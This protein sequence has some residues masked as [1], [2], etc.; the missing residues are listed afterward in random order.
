MSF[1]T[2]PF[3]GDGTLGFNSGISSAL[4]TAADAQARAAY[5]QG[6]LQFQNDQLAF[7]MAQQAYSNAISMGSAY[8]YAPGGNWFQWPRGG[9]PNLTQPAPGTPT[10]AGTQ[11]LQQ[12]I[13]QQLQ[14]QLG[15]AGVTGQFAQ[16]L[17]SQYT[18]G[19]VL[20]AAST[21][22][23][24][25]NAYGIVQPDGSVQMVTT[26]A[27]QQTAAQRGLSV[28]QLT[29]NAQTVDFNTLQR[30][31]QGPPTAAPQPTLAAQ[32]QQFGQAQTAAGLT[33]L[34]TDPTQNAAALSAQG[35]TLNG[36]SW[37]SLSSADQQYW[38]QYNQNNPTLAAQA[39]AGAINNAMLKAG[40]GQPQ[41][42]VPTLALQQMYGTY[43]TPTAGQ[44]TLQAQQQA[45][46]QGLGTAQFGLSVQQAQ[47]QGAQQYLGLLSQL[48]GPADYGRYLKVLGSTPAG[49]QDLVSASAGRYLPGGGTTGTAPQAQTLQNLVGAATGF[50]GGGSGSSAPAQPTAQ[51]VPGAGSPGAASPGGMNFQNFL[52]TAQGLPAPNQIAPQAFNALQPSQKQMLGSMFG[53]LGY[54]P[55]DIN[56]LYQMSLPKYAAGTA[57]GN[58][59]LQ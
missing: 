33:G 52:A 11:A 14:N 40:G 37:E 12:L 29:Q 38:L 53:N 44:S 2:D 16:P 9:Q 5:Q 31:A 46:Q 19:T 6:L 56:S 34:F 39:W 7:Q 54:A 27:L 25:G 10:L 23:G 59:R 47:Q 15:Q 43:G 8:G 45:F 32:Q 24:L 58:F 17:P 21:T 20:Q 51:Q 41:A 1:G 28:Q 50:G 22:P 30:L 13:N 18:P 49:L 35:R 55:T 36:Q 57:V 42:P 48:Q 4:T 3:M 26:A